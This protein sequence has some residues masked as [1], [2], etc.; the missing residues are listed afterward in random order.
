M[1]DQRDDMLDQDGDALADYEEE[2]PPEPKPRRPV[3]EDMDP[4]D[5]A[6]PVDP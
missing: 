6:D 4:K 1:P 2:R 3:A 5:P